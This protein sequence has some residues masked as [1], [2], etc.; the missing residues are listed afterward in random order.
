MSNL[1]HLTK[2]YGRRLDLPPFEGQEL[3]IARLDPVIRALAELRYN[4]HSKERGTKQ[5]KL[6]EGYPPWWHHYKG[7]HGE[8]GLADMMG[9]KVQWQSDRRDPGYDFRGILRINDRARI[10]RVDSKAFEEGP[11]HKDTVLLRGDGIVRL[12]E[13]MIYVWCGYHLQ[14][15]MAWPDG[16]LTG[17]E[18]NIERRVPWGDIEV[19]RPQLHSMTDLVHATWPNH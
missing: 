1:D 4:R 19:P 16:W 12:P 13:D 8:R 5:F 9:W 7:I 2:D 10:W 6:K 11:K 18:I 3:N 14:Q 15:D 17:P